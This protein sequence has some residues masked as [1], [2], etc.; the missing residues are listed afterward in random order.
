[1]KLL[2]ENLSVIRGE[3]LIFSDL[4]FSL[5]SG[6]ALMIRGANGAGKSTLLRAVAG[7]LPLD[8][9]S[10]SHDDPDGEFGDTR[11]AEL[12]HYLGHDN[13]MKAAMS[14]EENLAFWQEFAGQPHLDVDEALEMVGLDGLG[15]VPFSHLS[16]GQRR[17]IGIARLLVSYRPIWLLDE[18]TSGL[19]AASEAQFA[20]LMEAHLEDG[21]L[22]LAATHV[23]LG[24]TGAKEFMFDA[25]S[26]ASMGAP[27]A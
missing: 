22:I 23:P 25:P 10:I 13:A 27:A 14:V 19:D 15:P 12:C 5:S 4:S 7:L 1:M 8:E 18:P 20:A 16:T 21:G 6:E 26:D 24:L 3:D 11:L 2:V 17:R 9:G